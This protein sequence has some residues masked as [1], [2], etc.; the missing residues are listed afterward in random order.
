MYHCCRLVYKKSKGRGVHTIV[1]VIV[2]H[3]YLVLGGG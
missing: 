1:I 3:H 2:A